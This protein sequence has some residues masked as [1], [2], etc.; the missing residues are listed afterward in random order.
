MKFSGYEIQYRGK[1][2]MPF[3]GLVVM[4]ELLERTGILLQIQQC[5]IPETPRPTDTIPWR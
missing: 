3:G 1:P 5:D 2:V 4:K